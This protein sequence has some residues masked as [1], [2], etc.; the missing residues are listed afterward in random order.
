M[1]QETQ[2]CLSKPSSW[3]FSSDADANS[4]ISERDE[5]KKNPHQL[6]YQTERWSPVIESIADTSKERVAV[7]NFAIGLFEIIFY[8]LD[9]FQARFWLDYNLI[10]KLIGDWLIID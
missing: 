2:G 10:G 9:A 8:V 6:H 7:A 4:S 1:I 5:N 3:S